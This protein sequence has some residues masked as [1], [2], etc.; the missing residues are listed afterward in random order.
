MFEIAVAFISCEQT[1]RT[2]IV[3]RGAFEMS[4]VEF[5][6][7]EDAETIRPGL[8]IT[9]VPKKNVATGLHS[10][11]IFF[12]RSTRYRTETDLR[13]IGHVRPREGSI[14]PRLGLELGFPLERIGGDEFAPTALVSP[15]VIVLP[16]S[17]A[18]KSRRP[19]TVWPRASTRRGRTGPRAS[20]NY[21]APRLRAPDR[22]NYDYCLSA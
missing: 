18:R 19:E 7:P 20:D 10:Y 11:G 6:T 15:F 4:S 8:L 21:R 22:S 5:Y 9:R 14:P 16:V 17:P 1:R 2:R 13:V 3:R 12:P